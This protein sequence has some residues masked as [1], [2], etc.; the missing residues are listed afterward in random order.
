MNVDVDHVSSRDAAP[1]SSPAAPHV[2]DA[3]D[4]VGDRACLNCG[5]ALVG[6]FCA[7][8]GQRAVPPY[9]TLRELVG[10]AF[11]E[12]SGWDGTL[13]RD[14]SRASAAARAR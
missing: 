8:C 9:P 7:E 6:P 10:D 4:H 1:S 2:V 3:R 14:R 13:R 11:A 12:L 5:S